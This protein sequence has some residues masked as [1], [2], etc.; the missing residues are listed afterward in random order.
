MTWAI[1]YP[2]AV[3]NPGDQNNY[4]GDT[5]NLTIMPAMRRAALTFT[6]T[7]LPTG[8]SIDTSTGV[9]SGTISSGTAASS[10]F[11]TTI[12]ASTGTYN[13]SQ[14]TT[15]T[16]NSGPVLLTSPGDQTN[17]DCD[18]VNLSIPSSDS[19][20]S[21][22]AFTAAGLPAGLSIDSSTGLIS[23]TISLSADLSGP[24]TVTITA[25]DGSAGLA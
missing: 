3:T 17:F 22:L 2:V 4:D 18:T 7:G 25:S 24:Y 10:P 20:S 19:T 16:V 13:A 23:G 6:A 5:V 9:I 14:T 1:N 12:T 8:L 11:T 15:W 21:T